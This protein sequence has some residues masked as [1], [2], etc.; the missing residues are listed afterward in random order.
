MKVKI[1]EILC[2]R[3]IGRF[4]YKKKELPCQIKFE[5]KHHSLWQIYH[6][7]KYNEVTF[8][9]FWDCF[10]IILLKLVRLNKSK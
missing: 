10:C 6:K 9:L 8:V 5:Y 4:I 7:A 1:G 3:N 2:I